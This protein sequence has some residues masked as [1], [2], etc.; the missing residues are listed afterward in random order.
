MVQ[1]WGGWGF[2]VGG[3]GLGWLVVQGWGGLGVQALALA[4]GWYWGFM[5]QGSGL[6]GPSS[7]WGAV[8]RAYDG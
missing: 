7:G 3:S 8:G 2:R 6:S 1:G 4:L 5:V